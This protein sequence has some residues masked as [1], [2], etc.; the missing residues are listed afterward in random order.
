MTFLHILIDINTITIISN[1][2]ANIINI[3]NSHKLSSQKF[4]SSLFEE[5]EFIPLFNNNIRN[6]LFKKLK[7]S[8]NIYNIIFIYNFKI[9]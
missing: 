2:I 7:Y 5:F 3:I 9:Y 1:A 8:K 4:E 6:I